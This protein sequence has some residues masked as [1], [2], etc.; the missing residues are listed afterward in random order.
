MELTEFTPIRVSGEV[1]PA[2]YIQISSSSL[3]A[4]GNV[5]CVK[6]ATQ[7]LESLVRVRL[8]ITLPEQSSHMYAFLQSTADQSAGRVPSPILF[9]TSD[10]KNRGPKGRLTVPDVI[11]HPSPVL[12]GST[13]SRHFA[14][15]PTGDQSQA[16]SDRPVL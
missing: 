7:K 13:S 3:R 14:A 4:L 6:S 5:Q 1:F 9:G 10:T 8:V 2:M 11:L 16:P 12:F 15:R